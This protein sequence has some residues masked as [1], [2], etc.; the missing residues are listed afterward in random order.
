MTITTMNAMM[1]SALRSA[2]YLIFFMTAVVLFTL[3]PRIE[4]LISPVIGAFEVERTWQDNGNFYAE[5]AMLKLRGECEPTDIVMWTGGGFRDRNAKIVKI[6]YSPDP[7]SKS[8]KFIN[9]PQGS[10]H[11]GPWQFIS[12]N[13]PLGPIISIVVRHK[14]HSL[15]QQSQTIYTGLTRDFFPG[16]TLD[17]ETGE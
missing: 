3:G 11:W 10:Q 7:M 13:E 1:R 15:W 9:R 2:I 4:A 14:C 8:S 12:P 6:D 17:T 16:M 5:G